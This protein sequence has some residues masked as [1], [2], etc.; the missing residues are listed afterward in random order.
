MFVHR[1]QG[2]FLSVNV[3]DIELAGK[4][5]IMAPMWK[6][7]MKNVN[8][9]EP[10]SFLDHVHLGCTQRECKPNETLNEQYK[11]MSESRISAG[12]MEKWPWWEKP[13]AQTVA[14]SNDMEGHAQKCVERYCEL[15]NKKVEQLCKVSNPCLH[16][17]Q[18]KQEELESVGEL[19]EVCSH[20]V[21]KCLHLARIGRPDI[22]WWQTFSKA[23]L[24]HSSH[25]RFPTTLPCGK[26]G[27]ASQTRFVSRLR[28]CWL[29]WGLNGNLR[30]CLVFFGL[31]VQEK[32]CCLAQF[33]KSEIISLDAGLRMGGLLALDLGDMV[34]E[35]S[36]STNNNVQP[37][38]TSI[39][40]TGATLH[41]KTKAQKV[42]RKQ[43]V[44]QLNDVD[45]VPTDTHSSHCESQ[46]YIFEDNEAVTKMII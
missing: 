24:L 41:P 44:D 8:I 5:Q 20:F 29:S 46:Q 19:S 32:N 45:H 18:F 22:L 40:E 27:T 42:K 7:L 10:A 6:K 43:K 30:R 33:Y 21:L 4:K 23:D 2:L 1:K 34:I 9:N 11:K 17:H 13:H 14:R 25:K 31:D 16:D 38:H 12:A 26:H 3:D 37:Q 35:V 28:H 15:A 36:C 39:Q